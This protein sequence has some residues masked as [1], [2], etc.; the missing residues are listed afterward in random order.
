MVRTLKELTIATLE[1]WTKAPTLGPPSS[2]PISQEWCWLARWGSVRHLQTWTHPRLSLEP[3]KPAGFLQ[4]QDGTATASFQ[5]AGIDLKLRKHMNQ[6]LHQL[7]QKGSQ[8]YL[9]VIVTNVQSKVTFLFL[10]V[11]MWATTLS[12]ILQ[13]MRS[14]SGGE[15]QE[16]DVYL[17][18]VSQRHT[19][20]L[21]R[22]RSHFLPG[23]PLDVVVGV[24][25]TNPQ[26]CTR[27]GQWPWNNLHW[28]LAGSSPPPW[29]LCS[30]WRSCAHPSI[31]F[32][33]ALARSDRPAGG[34]VY[35]V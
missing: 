31:H 13:Q 32:R 34:G 19:I 7:R 4:V 29:W 33:D 18:I 26:G 5:L 24:K 8:L 1:Y 2:P 23:Y 15:V 10:R 12:A 6:T 14:G 21:S 17:P 16:A 20:D 9:R 25:F 22:T 3:H 35:C 28:V 30:S 11:L 27:V